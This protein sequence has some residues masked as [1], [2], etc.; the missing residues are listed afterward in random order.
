[1]GGVELFSSY[2]SELIYKLNNL[3]RNWVGINDKKRTSYVVRMVG[4]ATLVG[5]WVGG[6]VRGM[7]GAVTG[8]AI[9]GAIS[10]STSIFSS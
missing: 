6:H 4:L 1:M 2:R 7:P 8:A 3:R 9:G 5:A 10:I